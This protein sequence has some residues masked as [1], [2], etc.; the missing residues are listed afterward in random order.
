MNGSITS[1]EIET[2]VKRL[3][4]NRNTGSDGF[5]EKLYQIFREELTLIFLKLSPKLLLLLFSD[6]VMSESVTPW[7]EAHQAFLPFT[8]SWSLPKFMSIASMMPPSHLIF[9][10]PLLLLPSFYPSIRDFSNELAIHTRWPKF[11][12]FSFGINPSNEYSGLISFR[13]D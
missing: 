10:P 1:T 6:S 7:T 11:W 8:I 2:V 13:I 12:S 3:A 5:I 9:W 4:I